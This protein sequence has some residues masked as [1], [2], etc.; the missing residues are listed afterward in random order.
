[1][2]SSWL[3]RDHPGGH[4]R[5]P[6]AHPAPDQNRTARPRPRAEDHG[7]LMPV[8]PASAPPPLRFLFFGA[9]AVGSLLGARLAQAGSE[10]TLVGRPSH[11]EAVTRD[12]VR[13][14]SAG[15]VSSQSV[16]PARP[17]LADAGG[18][19]DYVLLTVQ[20]YDTLDAIEQ[21]QLVLRPGT[22]RGSF[23]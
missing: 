11:V 7:T 15:K 1:M 18:P 16:R 9:G 12:G 10:V 5:R 22:I 14:V 13:M 4:A 21:L 3:A 23:P 6:G 17:S 19:F 20:S 8:R 2:A